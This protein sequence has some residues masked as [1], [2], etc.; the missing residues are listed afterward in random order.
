MKK[1]PMIALVAA[2]ACSP[3]S[4]TPFG[5]ID[6]GF[7][8]R[9][10]SLPPHNIGWRR[11]RDKRHEKI[12]IGRGVV[13][14]SYYGGGERLNRHTANGEVFRPGGLTAA[15]RTLPMGTKLQVCY[16]GCAVVRVNDRGPAAWTGRVLDLA[17]DAAQAIGMSGV[18]RV[19]V[20]ILGR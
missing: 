12:H 6:W 1:L 7:G 9:V 11:L 4:A 16:R 19:R 18:A 15:H 2:L 5:D 14:S 3:A 10:A 13:L 20:A 8:Q 17:R